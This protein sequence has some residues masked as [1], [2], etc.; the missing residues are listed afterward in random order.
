VNKAKK[1]LCAAMPVAWSQI[2]LPVLPEDTAAPLSCLETH[3]FW[4][5]ASTKF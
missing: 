2:L 5:N 4:F 1:I 3:D